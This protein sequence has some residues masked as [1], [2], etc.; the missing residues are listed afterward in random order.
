ME[1]RPAHVER[2]FQALPS[3]R[4]PGMEP[5]EGED[6][7][8]ALVYRGPGEIGVEDRPD[9][10]PGSNE[11]LLRITATG[12]CGSDLHGYT[13]ENKRRHPGQVMGHEAVGRIVAAGSA[14]P[15]EGRTAGR[16]GPPDPARGAGV[17]GPGAGGDAA[18][19]P[20]ADGDGG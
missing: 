8:R 13:G 9:P 4:L 14:A 20:P 12:I 19:G 5:A 11:V 16:G 10:R 18:Q 3:R 1:V 7:V 17:G 6:P 15:D 2:P